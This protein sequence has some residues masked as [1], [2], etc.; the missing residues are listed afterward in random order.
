M[1]IYILYACRP[2]GKPEFQS[3]ECHAETTDQLDHLCGDPPVGSVSP[4]R[5]YGRIPIHSRWCPNSA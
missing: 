4:S 3:V 1:Y 5:I 2:V